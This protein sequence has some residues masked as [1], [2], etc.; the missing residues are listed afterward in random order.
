MHAL[1][2]GDRDVTLCA[3]EIWITAGD[4]TGELDVNHWNLSIGV[5]RAYWFKTSEGSSDDPT[6]TAVT[7][8][9][10]VGRR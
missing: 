10:L 6:L 1:S 2:P 7:D 8:E 3:F 9:L 4:V 5:D